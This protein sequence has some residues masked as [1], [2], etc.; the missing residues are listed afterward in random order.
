MHRLAERDGSDVGSGYDSDTFYV[1]NIDQVE[2]KEPVRD[3][4]WKAI[5]KMGSKFHTFEIDT[6]A[7][8]TVEPLNIIDNQRVI[9]MFG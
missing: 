8:K 9:N 5:L 1:G 2:S 6:E 4:Q 3:D 7:H